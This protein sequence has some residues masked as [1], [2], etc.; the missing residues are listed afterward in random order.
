MRLAVMFALSASVLAPAQAPTGPKLV[1]DAKYFY[2]SKVERGTVATHHFRITNAGDAP[3]AIQQ[4]RPTCGCTATT[5]GK[6]KL[7]PGESTELEV[8]FHT[9]LY[10]GMTS[11]RILIVSNDKA[12]PNQTITVEADV[13]FT[14]AVS[15]NS[16]A[17]SD[18]RPGERRKA[19]VQV[20]S[21]TGQAIEVDA[22][23]L[24]E[25]P[26]L[27]V[28]TREEGN[29]VFVDYELAADQLPA[30]KP[31]GTD[32]VTLSVHNPK[33][34]QVKLVV[35]WD[36]HPFIQAVPARVALAGP[37]G[38]ARTATV[39][40]KH[41]D[42]RPFRILS[43]RASSPLL[44]VA[45]LPAEAAARQSVQITLAAEA[46]A[47]TYDERVILVLDDPAQPELAV[48]VAASLR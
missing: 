26:W 44:R 45:A 46:P 24:S 41:E 39:V 3:L 5:L 35:N 14:V 13:T 6:D 31:S 7:A 19:S 9:G 1:L 17:F 23:D 25:A 10:K 27:G 16:V 8:N 36:R 20:E 21:G 4:V 32:L 37:A 11:K 34:A 48:R 29:D 47:G 40:L 28:S 30:G 43:A 12:K 38:T 2:F 18:L 22:V 33:P 42:K 15:A